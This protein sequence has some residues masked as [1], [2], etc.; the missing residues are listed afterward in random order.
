MDWNSKFT[1]KEQE[2]LLARAERVSNISKDKDTVN[3][4]TALVIGIGEEQY[5]LPIH[6]LV[7]VHE[8]VGVIAVPCVPSHIAG[9][10]NI[11]GHIVSVLQMGVLLDVVIDDVDDLNALVVAANDSMTVAFQVKA[12]GEVVSFSE[13]DINNIPANLETK[14]S[15]KY[16]K[17][18]LPNDAILLDIDAILNDES[19][20][21]NE[22]VG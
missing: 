22:F 19:L 7:N 13:N 16:L 3:T 21:V 4:Q 18:I 20:I 12:I 5:A 10:A 17:G 11:R 2:I 1:K 8:N 9:I 15:S 6:R 14:R